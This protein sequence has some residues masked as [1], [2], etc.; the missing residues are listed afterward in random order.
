MNEGFRKQIQTMQS[1]GERL[2]HKFDA[3][4]Y[5]QIRRKGKVYI[6][7]SS[8]RDNWPLTQECLVSY[9]VSLSDSIMVYSLVGTMLPSTVGEDTRSIPPRSFKRGR[10]LI[11]GCVGFVK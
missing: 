2:R 4:V 7:T 3:E 1:K 9:S 10:T 11:S 8:M 6:Y 5:I